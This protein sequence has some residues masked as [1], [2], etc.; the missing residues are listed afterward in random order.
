MLTTNVAMTTSA[1]A[2]Q[3]AYERLDRN[4]CFF[5]GASPEEKPHREGAGIQRVAAEFV[6]RKV[7]AIDQP[8]VRASPRQHDRG[9]RAGRPRTNDQ[10]IDHLVIG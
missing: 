2:R 1:S 4:V 10:D 7:R 5:P 6:A 3:S 9:N 8:H